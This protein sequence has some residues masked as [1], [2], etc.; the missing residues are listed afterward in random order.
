VLTISRRFG[1]PPNFSKRELA[2]ICS[3]LKLG[4]LAGLIG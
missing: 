3:T 2:I 4:C 1:S